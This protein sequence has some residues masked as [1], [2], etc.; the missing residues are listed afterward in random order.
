MINH[1]FRKNA[2]ILGGSTDLGKRIMD[3][4]TK[5]IYKRWNVLNIDKTSNPAASKN[6]LLDW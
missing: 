1:R 3:R 2:L 6:F 4:F 5:V